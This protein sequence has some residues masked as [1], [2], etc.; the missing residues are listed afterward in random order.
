L[1]LYE[2][3]VPAKVQLL[4]KREERKTTKRKKRKRNPVKEKELKSFT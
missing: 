4:R 3:G 2:A 1:L